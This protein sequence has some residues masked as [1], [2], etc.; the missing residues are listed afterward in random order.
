MAFNLR[1]YGIL[2]SDNHVLVTHESYRDRHFTKFPGGGLENGE[3]LKD[4]LVREFMEELNIKID[5]EKLFYVND[6]YQQSAFCAD[7]QIISFYFFVRPKEKEK[8]K[9]QIRIIQKNNNP[10]QPDWIDL[11]TISAEN[12]QFPIDKLVS[13]RLAAFTLNSHN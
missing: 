13:E 7:D 2:I 10:E 6:F 9:E 11:R 8:M 5:V 3:G 12:F 1:V 4:C